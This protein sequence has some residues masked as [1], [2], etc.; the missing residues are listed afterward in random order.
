MMWEEREKYY[1]RGSNY[2]INTMVKFSVKSEFMK[3]G[4][5]LVKIMTT[6]SQGDNTLVLE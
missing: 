6:L 2:K 4:D 5:G 1:G 3:K